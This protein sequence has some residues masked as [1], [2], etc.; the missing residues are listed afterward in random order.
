[1]PASPFLAWCEAV[2]WHAK[3]PHVSGCMR[4]ALMLRVG[5]RCCRCAGGAIWRPAPLAAA[6]A[7]AL[8]AS[9][10]P[11]TINM[12]IAATTPPT[13]TPCSVLVAAAVEEALGAVPLAA[14]TCSYFA[15]ICF[16]VSTFSYL[17][18]LDAPCFC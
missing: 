15:I 10:T 3:V 4:Q 18:P 7:A 17:L 1:M 12:F 9:M 5:R 13:T 16:Y 14:A 11:T 2:Q 8:P 6:A